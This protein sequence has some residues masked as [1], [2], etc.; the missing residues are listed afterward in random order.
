MPEAFSKP[1][2]IS[3]MMRHIESPDIEQFIQGFS[4]IFSDI[5]QD[6]PMLTHAL[7]Y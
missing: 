2:Q 4:D 5:Q 3:K 1:C 7:T 6:S